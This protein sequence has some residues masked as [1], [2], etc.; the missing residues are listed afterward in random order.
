[1]VR[2]DR[3]VAAM[4]SSRSVNPRSEDVRRVVESELI[5]V[6]EVCL[7]PLRGWSIF[8]LYPRLAPWALMFRRFAVALRPGCTFTPYW[9]VTE[10]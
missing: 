7:P 10:A 6:K 9:I 3:I 1:M 8:G 5:D 4:M 2:I